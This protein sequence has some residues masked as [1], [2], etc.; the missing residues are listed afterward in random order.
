[1]DSGWIQA[2]MGDSTKHSLKASGN[3]ILNAIKSNVCHILFYDILYVRLIFIFQIISIDSRC[4]DLCSGN[5]S[6][7]P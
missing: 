4:Q 5:I 3:G 1:M 6:L 7:S 2:S